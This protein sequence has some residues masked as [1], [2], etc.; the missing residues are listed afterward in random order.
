MGVSPAGLEKGLKRADAAVSNFAASATSL[1]GVLV[2]LAG[3]LALREGVRAIVGGIGSAVKSASDLNE[4]VSKSRTVFGAAAGGIE[5]DAQQMADAFGYS[6]AQFIEGA[7]SIGLIAK[8][9]GL[10]QP[11][12]AK[13]GSNFAKLAADAASFYNVP[14]DEALGA[15][16]SGLVGESEPMRR[17]GVLLNEDAVKAEAMALG[18][19]K[20]GDKLTEGAKVQARASLITKGLADAQGDLA[21]TAGSAANQIRTVW[22]R[23]ENLGA[24]L[25]T[26]IQ[27]ATDAVLTLANTAVAA[28]G[29]AVA[30][31]K[32][33]VTA[34]AKAATD[35]GGLIFSAFEKAGKGIAT[36]LDILDA[37]GVALNYHRVA[38]ADFNRQL[39]N[40]KLRIDQIG[41]G[42]EKAFGVVTDASKKAVAD[43]GWAAI[44]AQKEY[45]Q[46]NAAFNKG[47][48]PKNN[49]EKFTAIFDD[50]RNKAIDAL[51]PVVNLGD[52]MKGLAPALAGVAGMG[53]PGMGLGGIFGGMMANL[54]PRG[55]AAPPSAA[56][57]KITAAMDALRQEIAAFGKTPTGARVAELK[58]AGATNKDVGGVATLSR[59]LEGLKLKQETMKP[60]EILAKRMAELDELR[61]SRAVDFETYRRGVQGARKDYYGAVESGPTHA[62]AVLKGSQEAYAAQVR[63]VQGGRI[64]EPIK[65]VAETNRKQVD[66]QAKM[67]AALNK[68]VSRATGAPFSV[69]PFPGQ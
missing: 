41:L 46:L 60:A 20:A 64:D 13:L 65:D 53:F 1:K 47:L 29:T 17:F 58:A 43:S 66:L 16:R 63:A 67:V 45:E 39:A 36:T 54:N 30:A 14:V 51:K 24:E 42:I 37:L 32:D 69:V 18:L 5:A 55:L 48:V 25:G 19:A 49:R 56:A 26:A 21:R 28:L 34:W 12:A 10:T 33:A 9:S 15:I 57:G 38:W 3:A 27:P 6:K 4:Q 22:G 61:S 7:S 8:A 50:I 59:H 31:N 2:G 62:G 23:L 35:G 11:A 52:A 44:Q 68:I 40:L